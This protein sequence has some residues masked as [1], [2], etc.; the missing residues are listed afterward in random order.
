MNEN[1]VRLGPAIGHL[2]SISRAGLQPSI[3]DALSSRHARVYP[4]PML[5]SGEYAVAVSQFGDSWPPSEPEHIS[6][7]QVTIEKQRYA[8]LQEAAELH[9]QHKDERASELPWWNVIGRVGGVFRTDAKSVSLKEASAVNKLFLRQIRTGL[10]I[11][12]GVIHD[13]INASPFMPRVVNDG[14]HSAINAAW[15]DISKF[16]LD[17]FALGFILPKVAD[18]NGSTQPSGWLENITGAFLYALVPYDKTFWLRLTEPTHVLVQLAFLVP[19]A[20]IDSIT[21]ILKAF[22]CN[23]HD[24]HTYIHTYIHTYTHTHTHTHTHAHTSTHK[25]TH[26]HTHSLTH[27]P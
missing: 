26:T 5:R 19:F 8:L 16:V 2:W 3:G 14:L 22:A 23:K 4:N 21:V 10:A 6:T 1:S 24:R 25:H 13:Q 7:Q 27:T 12:A 9:E 20:G 17:Y 18:D 15:P 11:G